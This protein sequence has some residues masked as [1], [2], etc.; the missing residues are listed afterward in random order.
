MLDTQQ[1]AV[2]VLAVFAGA[3]V[4]STLG[5]GF[6]LTSGPLLLLVLDPQ[7]AVVVIN[8]SVAL[9]F[10]MV[11]VQ[12]RRHLRLR[13]VA[14]IA[15]GGLVGVPIGV[16][17]LNSVSAGSLRTG[18]AC[19]ILALTVMVA[20]NSR[21]SLLRQRPLG[22]VVGLVVGAL[23][24]ATSIGGPLL[25]LHLLSREWPRHAMR[26]SLSF[27]FLLVV[28][29]GVVGYGVAG[30]YTPERLT[31][32]LVAIAPLA[33]G[34]ALGGYLVGRMNEQVFRRGVLAVIAVTS[35]MVLG[36]EL[37]RLGVLD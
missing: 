1:I 30:M 20:F 28:S 22:P 7:T 23:V 24:A 16:T 19:L 27:F 15:A 18:I 3:T 14:P 21:V 33:A 25:A 11:V 29:T 5:F 34:F 36:Q 35:L 6:A 32:V 31:L 9:V 10:L 8:A 12:S 17:V 13:D 37:L 4:V 26:A 2:V